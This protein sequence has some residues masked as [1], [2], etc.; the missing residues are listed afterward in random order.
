MP[1]AQ[2]T[3]SSCALQLPVLS[4]LQSGKIS[5]LVKGWRQE[6]KW[7]LLIKVHCWLLA[8]TGPSDLHLP[9]S[10]AL[11]PRWLTLTPS[12]DSPS[13]ELS[14]PSQQCTVTCHLWSSSRMNL[15]PHVWFKG[16]MNTQG[17]RFSFFLLLTSQPMSHPAWSGVSSRCSVLESG[18]LRNMMCCQSTRCLGP[19][20]SRRPQVPFPFLIYPFPEPRGQMWG[21]ARQGASWSLMCPPVEWLVTSLECLGRIV[22]VWVKLAL[23]TALDLS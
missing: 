3:P 21:T 19:L 14:G 11:H 4:L 15:D 5:I 22:S 1:S 23:E 7:T 2:S 13:L 16:I 6:A 8:P 10:S 18:V 9:S 17:P 12:L 20:S